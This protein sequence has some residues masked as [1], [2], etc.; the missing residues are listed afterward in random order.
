MKRSFTKYPSNYV[1]SSILSANNT[2]DEWIDYICNKWA[3]EGADAGDIKL[4]RED[5]EYN[6][7]DQWIDA[8]E[9]TLGSYQFSQFKKSLNLKG[10]EDYVEVSDGR[11][12]NREEAYDWLTNKIDEF[13]N[14][15]S[16]DDD[17]KYDL[18]KLIKKFGNTY[19]WNK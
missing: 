4:F 1:R 7:F 9:E 2:K 11:I 13:G 5:A 16:W 12:N 6:L 10:Y 17:L 8:I 19:F 14:T 18:N 3:E 15:Y